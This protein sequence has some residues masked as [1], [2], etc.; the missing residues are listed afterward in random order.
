[1]KYKAKNKYTVYFKDQ[2]T[3]TS[4]GESDSLEKSTVAE[5]M[6]WLKMHIQKEILIAGKDLKDVEK[7]EIT[8][9]YED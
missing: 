8:L 2:T 3:F 5:E 7:I 9:A 6:D 4:T 1:M